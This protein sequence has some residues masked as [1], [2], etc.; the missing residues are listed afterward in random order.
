MHASSIPR[1]AHYIASAGILYTVIVIVQYIGG[2]RIWPYRGGVVDLVKGWGYKI[3]ER[4][5]G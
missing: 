2:S 1:K 5:E 4:V 3:N